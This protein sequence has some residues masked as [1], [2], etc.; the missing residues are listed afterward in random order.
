MLLKKLKEYYEFAI[1]VVMIVG[2]VA[3]FAKAE[4][5]N[6]LAQRLD[7]KI[8]RDQYRDQRRMMYEMEERNRDYGPDFMKWPD[9]RDRDLYKELKEDV[10]EMREK[11]K[12]KK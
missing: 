3:Y 12:E 9:K 5:L 7:Q 11:M 4:D 6:L 1:I 2:A 10:E 8:V